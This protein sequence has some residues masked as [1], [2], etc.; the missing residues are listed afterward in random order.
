MRSIFSKISNL[1]QI[2]SIKG[3]IYLLVFILIIASSVIF[4][5]LKV[6]DSLN[7][8]IQIEKNEKAIIKKEE[9]I[10]NITKLVKRISKLILLP[11]GENPIVYYIINPNRLIKEQE[12]FLGSQRGDVLVLY[13]KYSKAIIYSPDRNLIVNVGIMD[14]NKKDIN[15]QLETQEEKKQ[16]DTL[17]ELQEEK[18]QNDDKTEELQKKLQ[19]IDEKTKG[20]TRK[21]EKDRKEIKKSEKKSEKK[22]GKTTD[23]KSKA[24]T[25]N[26]P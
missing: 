6:N 25:Q 22:S 2:L 19:K 8:D 5:F 3:K 13:P 14:L 1:Y 11:Q 15:A 17:L 12:F 10:N 9:Y 23:T 24:K 16:V 18:K 26:N 20:D 4:I 7:V 21:K